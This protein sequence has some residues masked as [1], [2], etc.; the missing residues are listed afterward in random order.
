MSI[1]LM[2][3]IL[4]VLATLALVGYR[5]FITREEDDLV[6]L[7]EGSVQHSAR[8]E[9]MAKTITQLDRFLKIMVTVTVV[10]G[11]GLGALMIY[12][13]LSNTSNPL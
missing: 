1:P 6:H 5:K 12:Q 8:Q 2:L 10:Y 13:A 3:L 11:L 7:G 4:L 9:A